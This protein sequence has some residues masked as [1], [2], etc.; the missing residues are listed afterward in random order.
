MLW[1]VEPFLLNIG[2]VLLHCTN[3]HFYFG[4][5]CMKRIHFIWR[6]IFAQDVHFPSTNLQ[7]RCGFHTLVAVQIIL[8]PIG[9]F[10]L[11]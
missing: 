10:A 1:E 3:L 8:G 5:S 7:F 6:H 9:A 4:Q 2:A 11:D